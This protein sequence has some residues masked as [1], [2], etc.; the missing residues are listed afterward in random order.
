MASGNISLPEPLLFEIQNTA[1]AEHRSADEVVAD[2]MRVYLERQSWRKFVE[3]NEAR[4]RA[5]GFSEGDV[6]RLIAET[7][8]E[9]QQ[10]GR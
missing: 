4:A 3:K 6:D 2:A 9:N 5:K 10:R 7:R 1:Q 8:A